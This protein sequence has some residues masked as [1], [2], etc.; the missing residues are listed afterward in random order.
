M[1]GIAYVDYTYACI[2]FG[3]AYV[4]YTCVYIMETVIHD[5][6]VGW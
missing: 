4:D 6:W 3:I 5:I 2:T 1:F